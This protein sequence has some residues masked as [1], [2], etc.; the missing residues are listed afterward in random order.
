MT[1]YLMQHITFNAFYIYKAITIQINQTH[2][3][4]KSLCL[5]SFWGYRYSGLGTNVKES[6]ITSDS[7]ND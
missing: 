4:K 7:V 2:A 3:Q 1:K 6:D 5:S